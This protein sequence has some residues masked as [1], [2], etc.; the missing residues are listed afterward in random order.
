V[1]DWAAGITV[2]QGQIVVNNVTV[3]RAT[4]DLIILEADCASKYPGIVTTASSPRGASADFWASGE[5]LRAGATRLPTTVQ[6]P[7]RTQHWGLLAE[8]RRYSLYLVAYRR[9]G[10]AREIYRRPEMGEAAAATA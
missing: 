7:P 10:E 9:P 3:V 1:T 5:T 4:R 6:L 2:G 8:G